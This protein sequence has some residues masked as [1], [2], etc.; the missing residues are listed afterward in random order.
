MVSRLAPIPTASSDT[1]RPIDILCCYSLKARDVIEVP[2][3]LPK[4]TRV[5]QAV[6]LI[7]Q[8]LTLPA[9]VMQTFGVWGR[10]VDG[11]YELQSGDRLEFYRALT[12]DPKVARRQRFKKQGAKRSGLFAKRRPGAVAGY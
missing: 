6:E 12:V 7:Q 3:S 10:L 9:T 5:Q 2:I 11:A 1:A 8:Q 4:G